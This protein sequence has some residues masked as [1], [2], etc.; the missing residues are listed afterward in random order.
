MGNKIWRQC[1]RSAEIYGVFE[2]M[3]ACKRWGMVGN[4]LTLLKTKYTFSLNPLNE[5]YIYDEKNMVQA[6]MQMG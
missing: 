4:L 6:I 1:L 2:D 5:E 3:R